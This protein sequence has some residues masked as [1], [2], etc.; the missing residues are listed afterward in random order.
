MKVTT[1]EIYL[2]DL[3]WW[4][5]NCKLKGKSS[6]DCFREFKEKVNLKK[7]AEFYNGLSKPSNYRH[8]LL[9]KRI[10]KSKLTREL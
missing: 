1:I 3:P 2:E 7:Q 9:G 10:D 8:T 5:K 4:R 6:R